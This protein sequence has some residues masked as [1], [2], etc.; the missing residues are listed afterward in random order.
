MVSRTPPFF[1]F[2]S[3][4]SVFLAIC[5][6]T[7]IDNV[8]ILCLDRPFLLYHHPPSSLYLLKSSM[9]PPLN[10]PPFPFNSFFNYDPPQS[11]SPFL[12]FSIDLPP[13]IFDRSARNDPPYHI[14]PSKH[15]RVVPS[16]KLNDDLPFHI[17]PSK[18]CINPPSVVPNPTV[19][20]LVAIERIH[21]LLPGFIICLVDE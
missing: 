14:V 1:S 7:M 8:R 6:P 4:T 16:P 2:H 9:H 19:R 18:H 21:L 17:V 11:S 13:T 12:S 5:Y 20:P 3:L 15:R 10:H